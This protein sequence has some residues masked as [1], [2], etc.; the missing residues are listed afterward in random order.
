MVFTQTGVLA[1]LFPGRHSAAGRGAITPTA[2]I[3]ITTS[4][5]PAATVV[6]LDRQTAVEAFGDTL[7]SPS[8]YRAY[9]WAI[10]EGMPRTGVQYRR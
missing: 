8:P 9:E 1:D 6:L 10:Q 4:G 5:S 3:T 7:S 2:W